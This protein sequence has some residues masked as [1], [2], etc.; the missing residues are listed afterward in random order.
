M[1]WYDGFLEALR[2]LTARTDEDVVIGIETQGGGGGGID[3][4]LCW[5]MARPTKSLHRCTMEKSRFRRK[6][7]RHV[8]RTNGDARSEQGPLG[9]FLWLLI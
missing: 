2:H 4:S 7:C 9:I 3:A 6:S 5:A 8:T 1:L